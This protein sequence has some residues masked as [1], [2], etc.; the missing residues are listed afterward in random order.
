MLS[1]LFFIL[2]IYLLF[3]GSAPHVSP[4]VSPK[5]AGRYFQEA[6]LVGTSHTNLHGAHAEVHNTD[7][8]KGLL[9]D[10]RCERIQAQT[11][12][13][14]RRTGLQNVDS[15]VSLHQM[16]RSC[17]SSGRGNRPTDQQLIGN[18]H[19]ERH[20]PFHARMARVHIQELGT[21]L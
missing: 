12:Q 3:L 15:G 7:F 20:R 2:T 17:L 1:N 21:H 16:R 4:L 14:S 6:H 19:R 13:S 5:H 9:S 11:G 18:P 10:R 8:L